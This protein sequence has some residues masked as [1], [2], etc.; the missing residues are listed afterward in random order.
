MLGSSIH[1]RGT[2][3]DESGLQISMQQR[4]SQTLFISGAQKVGKVSR[5]VGSA[6]SYAAHTFSPSCVCISG[7]VC[8]LVCMCICVCV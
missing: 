5:G 6:C 4:Q 3:H 8:L 1:H 7:Y 2:P